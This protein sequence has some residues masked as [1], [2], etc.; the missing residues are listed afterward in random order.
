MPYSTRPGDVL[1][2]RYRLSD[3]LD[4]SEGARF[5]RATDGILQ[6]DVALH[7]V[8]ADDPRT[9]LLR[10]AARTSATVLDRRMLRVLDVDETDGLCFVVNEW[11]TGTSF[12]ILLANS[13]PQSSRRAAW[14]VAEVAEVVA[15]AHEA[16]VAHGRLVPENVLIDTHGAVRL[17]GLA[18]DA[19]LHGLP[20]GRRSADRVDLAGLLYAALT[21]KWA[22]VSRSAVPPA[23]AEHQRV[24]RPRQVRAGIPRPLDSLCDHVLNHGGEQTV[25]ARE[26]AEGLREFVGDESGQV[27]AEL[28][29]LDHPQRSTIVLPALPDPPMREADVPEPEPEPQPEPQPDDDTSPE[30]IAPEQPTQ[31]G[32]PIF[33]DENDE[34]TWLR[35]RS[36]PRTPP[37]PFDPPAQRPLFAPTPADGSP[38]RR[39]RPSSQAS[40]STSGGYWPWQHGEAG[41][42]TGAGTGSGMLRAVPEEDDDE[43]D[44]RVPGRSQ[45]RVAAL[46]AGGLLLLV[47]LVIAFNVGRGRTPLGGT[48]DS[49][50]RSPG[51]SSSSATT[52]STSST[53]P[54]TGITANDFDP[55]GSP[56]EENPEEAPNAVD[57]KPDTSW[58]TQTYNQDLG[59]AG[60]KTGVGLT[61]DLGA[62]H[63]V[64][65]V[66][67]SL[68]GTPSDLSIYVGD[69]PPRGVRGLT[70]AG[71][72]SGAGETAKVSLDP[73]AKGR[74]VTVW[75]TSLPAVSGGFRGEIAEARVLGE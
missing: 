35:A 44:R 34:V 10:E 64:S 9:P 21:G 56:P 5:W 15:V 51:R 26:I 73:A 45:L 17:I 25:T 69:T 11:G 29:R 13:G 55:Q 14:L 58:Q 54:I 3:L 32:M 67:L 53:A 20:A 57:G 52:G 28:A 7:I 60:L 47:A 48:A 59:P 24:L 63:T 27:S 6:R 75:L 49:S 74:Y 43:D 70:P 39:A 22:G 68:V 40:S 65:E 18:V 8:A 33:D 12:D 1:A 19:A 42:G 38:A 72:A 62:T 46:I 37:P 30:G 61:L 50:S 31:A 66:D 4:E 2:G 23:P 36:E 41:T 16:G 71:S